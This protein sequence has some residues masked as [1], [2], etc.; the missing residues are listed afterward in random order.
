MW[1]SMCVCIKMVEKSSIAQSIELGDFIEE[2][3]RSH[4]GSIERRAIGLSGHLLPKQ[5]SG[6]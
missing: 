4:S 3:V 2:I 6:A 1:I 5:R